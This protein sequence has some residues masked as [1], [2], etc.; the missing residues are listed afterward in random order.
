MRRFTCGVEGNKCSGGGTMAS[1]GLGG[2]IKTH[3]SPQEA[4][5]CKR[6]S[7][8]AEGYEQIGSREFRPPKGVGGGYILVL[9]KPSHFGGELRKGKTGEKGTGKARVMNN[10]GR[11]GYI[12]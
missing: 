5:R 7:L 1:H 8:I 2:F 6:A 4:F 12:A 11:A 10:S 3:S 9:S